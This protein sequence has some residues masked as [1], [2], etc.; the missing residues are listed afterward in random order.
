MTT[1]LA[2]HK[3]LG[4]REPRFLLAQPEMGSNLH[5]HNLM[6]C[7]IKWSRWRRGWTQQLSEQS[8]LQREQ[9]ELVHFIHVM[10][11]GQVKGSSRSS[12]NSSSRSQNLHCSAHSPL[13]TLLHT[14]GS[15]QELNHRRRRNQNNMVFRYNLHPHNQRRTMLQAKIKTSVRELGSSRNQC[16]AEN[17]FCTWKTTPDWP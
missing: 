7:S 11:K 14:Q 2:S 1:P 12:T 6:P 13:Q 17:R 8:K 5:H 9:A 3:L 10:L 15:L 4:I 16:R